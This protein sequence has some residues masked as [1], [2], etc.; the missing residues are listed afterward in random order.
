MRI[1][2]SFLIGL[3]A[4][5]SSLGAKEEALDEANTPFLGMHMRPMDQTD[6]ATY[7]LKEA[8]GVVITLTLEGGPAHAAGIKAKDAVV[9][10]GGT[11]LASG[12]D[13]LNSFRNALVKAKIGEPLSMDILTP[14]PRTV[15]LIPVAKGAW[16]TIY[17]RNLANKITRDVQELR[18][19]SAKRE[20]DIDLMSRKGLYEKM[21]HEY[22]RDMISSDSVKSEKVLTLA[23]MLPEGI[24]TREIFLRLL[25]QGVQGFYTPDEKAL[26][27]IEGQD[28]DDAESTMAHEITHGLQDQHFNLKS[29]PMMNH[30]NSDLAAA[31]R[32][33]VEGDAKILE[34]AYMKKHQ[35]KDGDKEWLTPQN[36]GGSF[37]PPT[38]KPEQRY[39]MNM[40]KEMMFPYMEGACFVKAVHDRGG[41]DA[42]NRLFDDWPLSTE[43]IIH[44]EKFLGPEID[45]PVEID[46]HDMIDKLDEV[47]ELCM[48][49]VVGELGMA[50]YSLNFLDRQHLDAESFAAGWD[51]D[52][53]VGGLTKENGRPYYIWMSVWDTEADAV[54]F[55]AGMGAI[56]QSRYNPEFLKASIKSTAPVDRL[57]VS[58]GPDGEAVVIREGTCVIVVQAESKAWVEDLITRAYTCHVRESKTRPL[59]KPA[60]PSLAQGGSV[61]PSKP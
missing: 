44:H 53:F 3:A 25:Q 14:A 34:L 26:F 49:D 35:G 19:L 47:S 2:F 41:W 29:L 9:G 48:S 12:P 7:A 51:G 38:L 43:Q 32:C 55:A 13:A 50:R 4:L 39:I 42:V 45:E 21:L 17:A 27:L 59:L 8:M 1:I 20:V 11:A 6:A 61:E 18:G 60:T 54:E 28:G 40:M 58:A 56:L 10:V 36:A 31:I 30:D 37:V 5:L 33:V 16:K 23:G 24:D 57:N 15:N 52:R 46:A 22:N